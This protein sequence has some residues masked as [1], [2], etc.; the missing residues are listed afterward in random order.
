MNDAD[1]I[2]CYAMPCRTNADARIMSHLSMPRPS[3]LEISAQGDVGCVYIS[4]RKGVC[5]CLGICMYV[6]CNNNR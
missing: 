5:V 3:T 2:P 4:E 6:R 1:A